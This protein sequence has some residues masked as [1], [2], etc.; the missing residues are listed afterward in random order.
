MHPNSHTTDNEQ[1]SLLETTM[2][3]EEQAYSRKGSPKLVSVKKQ[4]SKTLLH[5]CGRDSSKK[6][7][8]ISK[9]LSELDYIMQRVSRSKKELGNQKN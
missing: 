9:I 7:F 8:M 4:N 1:N 3:Q 5:S 6:R 2:A